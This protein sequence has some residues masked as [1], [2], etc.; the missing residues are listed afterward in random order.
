MLFYSILHVISFLRNRK[1]FWYFMDYDSL[2]IEIPFYHIWR[3]CLR[4][5]LRL[6]LQAKAWMCIGM[7]FQRKCNWNLLNKGSKKLGFVM[8]SIPAFF[9]IQEWTLKIIA[10]SFNRFIVRLVYRR[11]ACRH[12]CRRGSFIG[13]Q[14]LVLFIYDL[15]TSSLN[16]QTCNWSKY[17]FQV[18]LLSVL[19]LTWIS[20]RGFGSK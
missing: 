1:I 20:T 5:F 13:S 19:L 14:H 16:N 17:I 9:A 18:A 6:E 11:K 8:H 3:I 7:D 4:I 12:R 2:K 15:A 10:I